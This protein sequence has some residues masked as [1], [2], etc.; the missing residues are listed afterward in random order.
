MLVPLVRAVAVGQDEG[1]SECT[2][3]F[4]LSDVSDSKPVAAV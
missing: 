3:V 4:W 2:H 1:A